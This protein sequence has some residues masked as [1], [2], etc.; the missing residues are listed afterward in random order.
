[1]VKRWAD[2]TC[3]SL[4]GRE[5]VD[6]ST[7]LPDRFA[8]R[9]PPQGGVR[10]LLALAY[11]DRIAKSRGG[12]SGAISARQW[13]R[14]H[15]RSGLGAG[16]RAV[17]RGGGTDRRG[18][19]EPHHPGGADRARRN[20]RRALPTRSK[21]ARRSL[22]TC[23]LRIVARAAQP[24][25]RCVGAGRADEVRSRPMPRPRICSRKGIVS[26]SGLT[27]C[28]GASLRCN[29]RNRVQFLRTCGRRRMARSVR[30]RSCAQCGRMAGAV[31]RRQ[32]R[33]SANY[34]AEQ[35]SDGY[36]RA[37]CRGISRKRLDAEAPTHFTAPSG[38]HV[39]ID[40]EAEEGPTAI[41]PRAGIVRPFAS[42]RALPAGACRW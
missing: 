42:I 20:R 30:R 12:G 22:S 11:P 21:T 8:V 7:A 9:P 29:S 13:A 19:R 38:S 34:A 10:R 1:M 25:A 15:G 26:P 24:P 37:G 31:A 36:D 35:L 18:G 27:G 5:G 23:R 4:R 28:P 2:T 39:P 17:S 3:P 41:D 33:A 14:R 40:Y 32:D 16:A 6:A